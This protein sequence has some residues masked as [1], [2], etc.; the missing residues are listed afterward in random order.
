MAVQRKAAFIQGRTNT[1]DVGRRT[2]VWSG[3]VVG[4]RTCRGRERIW[5]P[6]GDL[7]ALHQVGGDFGSEPLVC[8]SFAFIAYIAHLRFGEIILNPD[9]L[10]LLV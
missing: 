3:L 5:K 10:S 4:T 9:Y 6:G 1:S 8:H 2:S 7:P